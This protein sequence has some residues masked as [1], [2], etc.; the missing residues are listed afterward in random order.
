M[1]PLGPARGELESR[2]VDLLVGG[3]HVLKRKGLDLEK[4]KARL[5][6]I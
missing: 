5:F 2:T 3:N 6:L 1:H 4:V